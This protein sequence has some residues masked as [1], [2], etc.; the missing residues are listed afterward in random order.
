VTD[1]LHHFTGPLPD[2]RRIYPPG[3][4]LEADADW[5]RDHPNRLARVRAYHDETRHDRRV[6]LVS[7]RLRD[8]AAPGGWRLAHVEG[9]S[10]HYDSPVF[11]T[12]RDDPSGP[13]ADALALHVLTAD[14]DVDGGHAA[15]ALALLVLPDPSGLPD[16]W[17]EQF[18]PRDPN[19]LPRE[20]NH[21]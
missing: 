2:L 8:A 6:L 4:D 3:L 18:A 13:H 12:W 9:H 10:A 17:R 21:A 5:L 7:V 1:G 20:A 11:R 14:A 15:T 19:P 16:P